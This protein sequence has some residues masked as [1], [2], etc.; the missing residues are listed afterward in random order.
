MEIGVQSV[1]S[2][3]WIPIFVGMGIEHSNEALE[4]PKIVN[5]LCRVS[6]CIGLIAY[7]E[8]VL[9]AF[10]KPSRIVG[11]DA[12]YDFLGDTQFPQSRQYHFVYIQET[13]WI[14]G[15]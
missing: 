3:F 1:I 15:L 4:T 6:G 9:T 2:R 10:E 5:P 14:V 8:S 11:A 13:V 7:F 12:F